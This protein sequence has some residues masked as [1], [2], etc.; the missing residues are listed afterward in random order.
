MVPLKQNKEYMDNRQYKKAKCLDSIQK[1]R[2]VD[3]MYIEIYI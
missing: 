3:K 1:E 2:N